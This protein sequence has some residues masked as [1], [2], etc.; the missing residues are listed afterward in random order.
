[1]IKRPRKIDLEYSAK[2]RRYE[3]Y[4]TLLSKVI[5]WAG[6]ILISFFGYKTAEVLAGR[7]TAS[8]IVFGVLADVRTSSGAA[9]IAAYFF[10]ASGL[11]F[12]LNQRR[13]RR[14]DIETR[15]DYLRQLEETLDRN[16][17][18]SR[19]T[20]RGTTSREG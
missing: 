7:T 20:K 1:M 18:S 11:G 3:L 4:G 5:P 13:L 14:K 16:R 19:L 12:G 15:S 6:C 10:G 9:K 8:Q 17:T 2:M